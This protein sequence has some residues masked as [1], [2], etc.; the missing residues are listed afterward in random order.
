MILRSTSLTV[1]QGMGTVAI[2][3]TFLSALALIAALLH[4]LGDGALRSRWARDAVLPP[5]VRMLGFERPPLVGLF[6]VWV[7][8]ALVLDPGSYHDVRQLNRSGVNVQTR[9][10]SE[11]FNAW[12]DRQPD[13][14]GT[15]SSLPLVVVAASGGGLRSA[16]WTSLVLDC[17]LERETD[18]K[19]GDPCGAK[20]DP[21]KVAQRRA[22]LFAMSGVSGGGLG[23]VTYD[24]H[25]DVDGTTS[26]AHWYDRRLGDDFL[27]PTVAWGLFRDTLAALLR[28]GGGRDR[29]AALERALGAPVA[30]GRRRAG[31]AVPH[32]PGRPRRPADLPQRLLGRGRLP[33]Q[34]LGRAHRGRA[35]RRPVRLPRPEVHRQRRHAAE[36]HLRRGRLPL[37]PQPR[38]APLHRGALLGARF[39]IISPAGRLLAACGL[40]QGSAPRS[41]SVDGGVRDS[42][43]A[44]TLAEL[45]PTVQSIVDKANAGGSC[46]VPYFVQIDSEQDVLPS[47]T[48]NASPRDLSAS[49]EALSSAPGGNADAA[50][51]AAQREFTGPVDQPG[52]RSPSLDGQQLLHPLAAARARGRTPGPRRPTSWVLSDDARQDLR[53]QV[54]YNADNITQLRRL[55][56]AT[57]GSLTCAGGAT[58]SP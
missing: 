33:P 28:P 10:I 24:T 7:A 1:A 30:P 11:V 18:P 49:L 14:G 58:T 43:A 35:A 19:T 5:S 39:P 27:G 26:E 15:T 21:D 22:R 16:Y 50:R 17:V 54:V 8:L 31:R 40:D 36:R 42:S 9:S 37:R 34:H 55:L 46:I 38:P 53:D 23:L 57:P 32:G 44:S 48:P 51:V 25:V 4:V 47:T 56:D 52:H 41:F 13:A 12:Q 6:V 20:A 45:W 29:A 2:F 3:L